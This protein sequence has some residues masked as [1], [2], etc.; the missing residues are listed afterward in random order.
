M[1]KDLSFLKEKY[2][3]HRGLHDK[4]IGA[5][6][7]TIKSFKRAINGGYPIELDVHLIKDDNIIV[8]HDDN[9][10]RMT[11]IDKKVKDMTYDEIKKIRLKDS[12]NYIPLLKEVLDLVDGKV[13]L[14]IELK[15]DRKKGLLEKKV[16]DMLKDYKGLY[17]IQSFSI[18][19]LLYLKKHYPYVLRGQL[20]SNIHNGKV[21][22]IIGF[23]SKHM[24][25]NF[26]TKPD[27]ISYD[28]RLLPNRKI[29]KLREK[30]LILGWTVRS[31]KD[32]KKGLK[33]CD[34]V[35]AERIL[36]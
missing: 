27:F 29:E 32:L 30:K 26:L 31:E 21:H 35:I 20:A 36:H 7:N 6:E 10:V 17:A 5:L 11:G 1:Q 8:F 28:I 12:N 24:I 3:V 25:F 23:Y 15:Y 4:S 34:N 2:I 33:Y 9:L 16:M 18:Q 13:P 22:P 14:L 19:S